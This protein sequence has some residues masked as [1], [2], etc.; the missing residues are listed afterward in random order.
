MPCSATAL[1]TQYMK[2]V[3]QWTLGELLNEMM[4]C[5]LLSLSLFK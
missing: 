4:V 3:D 1:F 2:T 5:F